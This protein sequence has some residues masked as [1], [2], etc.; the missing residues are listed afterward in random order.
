[1]V[2][3][4]YVSRICSYGAIN[5][6]IVVGILSY[7]FKMII[8]DYKFYK[9]TI[10]NRLYDCL[11]CFI[12]SQALQYLQILSYNLIRNTKYILFVYKRLPYRV[13]TTTRRYALNEAIS[14]KNNAHNQS[15]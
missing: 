13:I 11:R 9:L 8:W 12:I 15:N 5:K 14:I 3:S 6:L 1:M 7:D 10:Q 4:N 2:I